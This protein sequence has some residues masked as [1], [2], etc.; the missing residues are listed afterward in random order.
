MNKILSKRIN[1]TKIFLENE[2]EAKLFFHL[3][4]SIKILY[5]KQFCIDSLWLQLGIEKENFDLS[6]I[7][8]YHF[9]N[10]SNNEN[11]IDSNDLFFNIFA[12]KI[13]NALN[14]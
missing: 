13:I 12:S 4:S 1:F 10:Q 9:R 7:K 8:F 6:S 5:S 3:E 11:L 14:I 2:L